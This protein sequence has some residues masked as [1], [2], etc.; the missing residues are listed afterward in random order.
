M[1]DE[2]ANKNWSNQEWDSTVFMIVFLLIFAGFIGVCVHSKEFRT[3]D[4]AKN[5]MMVFSTVIGAMATYFFSKKQHQ[6]NGEQR[7]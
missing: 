7:P 3:S 1:S 6:P 5:L 4:I 2:K